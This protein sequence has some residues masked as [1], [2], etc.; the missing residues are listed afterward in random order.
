[1]KEFRSRTDDYMY[2]R[3]ELLYQALMYFLSKPMIE[4]I[5]R[6]TFLVDN[7]DRIGQEVKK[8]EDNVGN[9][10]SCF[11]LFVK[12]LTIFIETGQA[13]HGTWTIRR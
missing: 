8:T 12:F 5:E 6:E 13:L 2:L 10:D 1:M 4:E 3:Y 11:N 7:I 9:F